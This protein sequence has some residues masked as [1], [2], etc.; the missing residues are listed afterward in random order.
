MNEFVNKKNTHLEQLLI[1]INGIMFQTFF[2]GSD[3]SWKSSLD[4][5]IKIRNMILSVK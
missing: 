1:P 4:T 2:G 3:T 5:Y